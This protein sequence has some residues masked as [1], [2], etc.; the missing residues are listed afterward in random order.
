VT[1]LSLSTVYAT[2][3]DLYKH[4]IIKRLE[5]DRM[6]NRYEPNTA[7]HIDLICKGCRKIMDYKR[8]FT[9]D[10]HEISRKC[11]FWVTDRRRLVS[12]TKSAKEGSVMKLFMKVFFILSVVSII[13]GLGT[14]SYAQTKED[15]LIIN[16]SYAPEK[17]RPGNI[18]K[19][20][21]SVTDPEAKMH[22]VVCRVRLSGGEAY[23]AH[24]PITIYSTQMPLL[25]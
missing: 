13:F 16:F 20:Y 24:R 5:F 8:P 3:K 23:T 25:S 15:P 2:L 18:W 1:R 11:R 6:G 7:E 4:G 21:L 12:K 22:R 17:I 9:I 19:I 14:N 10:T